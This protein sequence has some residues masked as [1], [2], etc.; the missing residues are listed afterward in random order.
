[1]KRLSR[2]TIV[3]W[4]L[5]SAVAVS[6]AQAQTPSAQSAADVYHVLFAKAAPGQATALA[7]ELQEQ[8]PK[9]P[10]A[11]HYVLLRHQSGDDWDYCLIQ[12]LGA[13]ASV[14]LTNANPNAP[15]TMAWHTDTFVAGPSWGEVTRALVP[16]ADDKNASSP[17]YIVAVHRAVPGHRQQLE[18]VL[19]QVNADAKVP[20]ASVVF[21]HLEGGP[22]QF[23]A[24]DRY[25][26]WQDLATDRT[27]TAN[28]PGW[29][30]LRDH[31]AF[32][33]DTIADRIVAK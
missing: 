5:C 28:D 24:V 8:D 12:H 25:N 19:R 33:H 9:D 11:S 1:M 4:V 23:L 32:H 29:L 7:K 17:V 16:A 2:T 3:A 31:V 30:Q 15:P 18:G 20:I 14:D 6:Q 10:M 22:W 21:A 27:A 26:S 13:K